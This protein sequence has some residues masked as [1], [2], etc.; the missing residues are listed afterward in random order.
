MQNNRRFVLLLPILAMLVF[1]SCSGKA[2]APGE[3]DLGHNPTASEEGFFL[4]DTKDIT[5]SMK[6]FDYQIDGTTV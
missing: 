6:C 5:T 1:V 4:I 3:T 2:S